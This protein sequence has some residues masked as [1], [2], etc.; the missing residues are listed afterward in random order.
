M[1]NGKKTPFRNIVPFEE[2]ILYRQKG[3][4]RKKMKQQQNILFI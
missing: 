3:K 2:A 4:N 1:E